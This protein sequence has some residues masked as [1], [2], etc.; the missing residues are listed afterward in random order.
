MARAPDGGDG[1]IKGSGSV[2]I[3]DDDGE[4]LRRPDLPPCFGLRRVFAGGG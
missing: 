3:C 4:R 1:G 2:G